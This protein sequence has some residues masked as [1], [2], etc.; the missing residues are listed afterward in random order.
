M[1]PERLG[2]Q[3]AAPSFPAKER[4][5]KSIERRSG[6][7]ERSEAI[8]LLRGA[9]DCFAATRRAPLAAAARNDDSGRNDGD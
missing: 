4:A 1:R 7:C 2:A 8:Q 6:P 9:L 5:K 3:H